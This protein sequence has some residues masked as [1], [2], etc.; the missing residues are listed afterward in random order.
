MASGS[1]TGALPKVRVLFIVTGLILGLAG[2][3]L[4]VSRSYR[5]ASPVSEPWFEDVYAQSGIGFRHVS[6][7]GLGADGSAAPDG[8][9]SRLSSYTPTLFFPEIM[10]GGVALIDFDADGLLD[11]YFVQGGAILAPP[12]TRPGNKL[13]RNIGGGRFVDV[14]DGS[15]AS[16]TGYGMGV[17]VGDF[18]NDGREDIYITNVG[19]N[20][21]LKNNGDGTFTDVTQAADVGDAGFS[22]SAA[23][24]DFD[25]D[26]DLDLFVVNYVVWS[27]D[28]EQVCS[29]PTDT[30]GY[31]SPVTYD[32]PARDTLYR[33]D[34]D[35]T[36]VD[37]TAE[38]G[39]ASAYGNGLG[40][41]PAD[42]NGDGLIDLSVANDK[43]ANQLWINLGDGRFRDEAVSRGV[44][45]NGLGMA[46]AGMGIDARDI[47]GDGDL[48]LVMTHFAGETNTI[49]INQGDYFEDETARLGFS[50]S[51]AF[52]G[53]G[54]AIVDF[55]NDGAY[56]AFIVNGRV[57]DGGIAGSYGEPNQL[58]EGSV[59]GGFVEVVPRGGTL[60]PLVHT[61]RGAA[62]GDYDNDGDVDII[63]VNRDA[64]PY[65]LENRIG[66][67]HHWIVLRVLTQ[68]GRAALGARV[69]LVS[70][71]RKWTSDT[72]V[73]YSYCSSNDPRVHF[74][75]GHASRV[76][77]VTV[78]WP[79]GRTERFGAFVADQIVELREGSGTAG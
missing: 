16:D 50:P 32:A 8:S 7:E 52:T 10:S 25:G 9:K 21:L 28:T 20:V 30:H 75:L 66:A 19:P 17:T 72:R 56:D 14:S 31:C 26:G 49:Y 4:M 18:D 15:G 47:D 29:T 1:R 27:A 60:A 59:G 45:F 54:T 61:S 74:G 46:E 57:G 39:I 13:Y 40:V 70:G 79:S 64:A 63:V 3:G 22:S 58:Y 33:N 71:G 41:V 34:G 6:G 51:R 53:F 38:S 24:L 73:A 78:T 11:V 76:E 5:S 37:I 65:V 12:E 62:F 77:S 23:F 69:T 36:F 43:T 67:Q 2:V 48:D 55:N 44:A 35:G 68:S 42:L